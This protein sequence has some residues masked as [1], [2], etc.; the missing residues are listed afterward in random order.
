V[1]SPV[2]LEVAPGVFLAAGPDVNWILL[3]DGDVL[4]LVDAGYPGYA[5]RVEA[6]VAALGLRPEAIAAI[7]LTHAHVDH[8]GGLAHFHERYGTPVHA[9][10]D[11]VGHAHRDYLEQAGPADVARNVWR[12]GALGWT[13]RIVRS[14]ALEK[15]RAPFVSAYPGEGVLELPGRPVPVATP[16]HTS[17]HAAYFLPQHG[18]VI[19]GDALVTGHAMLRR[20]GPQ[21][22]PGMF[23]HGDAAA[24]LEPLTALAAEIVLPGHGDVYRG[25][26]AAAVAQARD[27]AGT[28]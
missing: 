15:V 2:P 4:T 18:V 20:T 24:G 3:R 21:L 13:L 16:G 27:R 5:P 19:T 17:G 25:P 7:L 11:E 23:Q 14:G 1:T 6:S 10:P 12:P 9:H 28:A 22:L 8:M 26:I